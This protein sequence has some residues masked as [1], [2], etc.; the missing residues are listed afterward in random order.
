MTW[1]NDILG[2]Q[3]PKCQVTHY[4]LSGGGSNR[5]HSELKGL[6]RR[7]WLVESATEARMATLRQGEPVE[8]PAP[9]LFPAACRR[10]K[11]LI[12][13]SFLASFFGKVALLW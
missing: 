6:C 10:Y 8:R 5:A 3:S 2:I 7:E 1:F 4:T 13:K 11:D 9:S 12:A